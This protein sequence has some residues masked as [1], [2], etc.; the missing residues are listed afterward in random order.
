MI[1]YSWL[2]VLKVGFLLL[3]S[4]LVGWLVVGWLGGRLV[5]VGYSVL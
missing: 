1:G 3:Q 2:V 5:I 4:W